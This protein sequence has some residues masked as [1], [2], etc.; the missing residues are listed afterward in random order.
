MR[1]FFEPVRRAM[2]FLPLALKFVVIG[3]VFALPLGYTVNSFNQVE[4]GQIAFSTKEQ[5]GLK[6]LTPAF[7]LLKA[8]VQARI[9]AVDGVPGVPGV[10]DS[11]YDEV[12]K[13]EAELGEGLLTTKAFAAMTETLDTVRAEADGYSDDASAAFAG[14]GSFNASVVSLI[15]AAGD[16]SNLTLDPDVDTYYI[17]N[18]IVFQAP[19]MYDALGQ[20]GDVLHTP[21]GAQACGTPDVVD[22]SIA[23]AVC[24]GNA[25]NTN[26]G[27]S[28]G[29]EIALT[30]TKDKTIQP[31]LEPLRKNFV[32]A[33]TATLEAAKTGVGDAELLAL[34]PEESD[35][36]A[37]L[38]PTRADA[39]KW[40]ADYHTEATTQLNNM[41]QTR[42][43]GFEAKK[44]AVI[45]V[46]VP[47]IIVALY[48]F[49]GFYYAVRGAVRPMTEVLKAVR[50]GDFSG[51]AKVDTRDEL[52][53]LA[54]DLNLTIGE[55]AESRESEQRMVTQIKKS[56]TELDGSSKQLAELA[57]SM[58]FTSSQTANQ[59]T[60]VSS[61]AELVSGNITTVAAGIDE[62]R[63]SVSEISRGANDATDIANAGVQ[64][65]AA[66]SETIMRLHEASAEIG[67]VT[68]LI[69][70]IA[71][72]TNLLALNATI[73][74]ARAGE[75]GKG[76]AVVANEVKDLATESS[77]A[78]DD[79]RARI[80][81]IQGVTSEA[82][83]AIQNVGEVI[84]Q[85]NEAQT[86]IAAAVEE[87]SATNDE[88]ARS[89][90]S[91]VVGIAEIADNVAGVADAASV[92]NTSAEDLRDAG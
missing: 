32:D 89:I 57:S 43:D 76:F 66:T 47:S 52:A 62:M 37:A 34:D 18:S 38:E 40:I 75:A 77:R 53:Q 69:S 20:M 16:G 23:F 64:A 10:V 56:S 28:A 50:S 33:T 11:A 7:E 29:I 85:I 90:N 9:D 59:A 5:V 74:A 45:N 13:V 92:T 24:Y 27:I 1:L 19:S 70:S 87:Q 46:V 48:C 2:G 72:Q 61:A 4:N 35:L 63:A 83:G 67:K 3:L 51:R 79:I 26:S 81:T 6:Y 42:V 82:V 36:H 41:I 21:D 71:K 12:K 14:W 73:E 39:L 55:M 25:T 60:A 91:V 88:I 68:D 49:M 86:T 44:S 54:R 30:S 8:G 78:A 65:A 58:A 84:A 17:M 15:T 80:A 31:I 22:Q